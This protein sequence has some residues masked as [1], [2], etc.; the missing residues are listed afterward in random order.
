MHDQRPNTFILDVILT[1]YFKFKKVRTLVYDAKFSPK[2]FL[3][4]YSWM[5]TLNLHN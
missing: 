2:V 4:V 1:G 5:D 3:L